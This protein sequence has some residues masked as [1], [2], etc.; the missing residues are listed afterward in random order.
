MR[1]ETR[2]LLDKAFSG[3][4][5]MDGKPSFSISGSASSSYTIRRSTTI[6]APVQDWNNVGTVNIDG[7]GSGTFMDHDPNLTFPAFYQAVGSSSN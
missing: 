2:K 7:T 6:A 5:L 4:G 1:L 3:F